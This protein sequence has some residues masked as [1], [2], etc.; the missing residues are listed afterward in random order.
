[1]FYELLISKN[2]K[3]KWMC[4]CLF[5]AHGFREVLRRFF[6][7]EENGGAGGGGQYVKWLL[8]LMQ[9]FLMVGKDC[10]S[11]VKHIYGMQKV[12]ESIPG[13]SS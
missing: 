8:H 4:H 9:R 13:I 5:A 3:L 2:T 12:P 11:M 1:M 6:L 7:F 10:S